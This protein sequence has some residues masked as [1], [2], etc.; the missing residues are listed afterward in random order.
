MVSVQLNTRPSAVQEVTPREKGKAAAG[1]RTNALP[2]HTCNKNPTPMTR[3]QVQKDARPNCGARE[4]T[5]R[6]KG[7]AA[8]CGHTTSVTIQDRCGVQK[9]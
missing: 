5:P 7:L 3:C 1:F 8:T 4:L 9:K 6:I 2:E